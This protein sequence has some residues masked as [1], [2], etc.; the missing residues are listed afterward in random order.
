ME[1][2]KNTSFRAPVC[3]TNSSTGVEDDGLVYTDVDVWIQKQGGPSIH[4]VL[5]SGQWFEIDPDNMPGIYDVNFEASDLDTVGFFKYTVASTGNN[6]YRGLLTIVNNLEEDSF[7]II[8][9]VQTTTNTIET[10][11]SSLQTTTN[12]IESDVNFIE[13]TVSSLQTTTNSIEST[14]NSIDSTVLSIEASTGLIQT[15][16]SSLQIDVNALESDINLIEA[17]SN[18]IENT[19][20][21]IQMTNN[22]TLDMVSGLDIHVYETVAD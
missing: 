12:L 4:R 10:T 11:V 2:K 1:V 17:S 8:S 7:G 14:V 3:M 22:L 5:T 18:N 20:L 6:T 15:T 19:V 21:D 13:T 9:S 16:V